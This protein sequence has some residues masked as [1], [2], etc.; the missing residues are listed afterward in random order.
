MGCDSGP[1]SFLS[2]RLLANLGVIMMEIWPVSVGLCHPFWS[3]GGRKQRQE[4]ASWFFLFLSE[5]TQFFSASDI[6]GNSEDAARNFQYS[7]IILA[8]L[9]PRSLGESS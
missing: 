5:D 9:P 8:K 2:G 4:D 1:C 6:L 7:Y 3:K